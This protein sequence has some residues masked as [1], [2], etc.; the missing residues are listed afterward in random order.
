MTGPRGRGPSVD[1][2]EASDTAMQAF[3][4][5][6]AVETL[7]A[8]AYDAVFLCG[9]HG[10]MWDFRE[11]PAIRRLV[12]TIDRRG[13]LIS[14]VCHG[15]AG[16]LSALG[17]DGR[18]LVEGRRVTGFTNAEEAA[19]D[20][21]DAVPYLLETALRRLGARFEAGA[22]FQPKVVRD[23]NLITGQNPASAGPMA[24]LVTAVLIE[25]GQARLS[26]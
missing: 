2:F 25:R 11:S 21:T 23:G 9:G 16:L 19:V 4:T 17:Q 6:P 26:R 24:D 10:T 12:E 8:A 7:D 3:R 22:N 20:L 1:R 14:A 5:M 18:P 15:P 13:A